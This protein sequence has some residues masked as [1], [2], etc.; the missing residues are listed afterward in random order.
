M[1]NETRWWDPESID[2]GHSL[3]VASI[4]EK[5][6]GYAFSYA[7]VEEV[8]AG[9]VSLELSPWPE[10]DE[11]GSPEFSD[12]RGSGL[13]CSEDGEPVRIL[14]VISQSLEEI[15]IE[16]FG[17]S[18]NARPVRVGDV[19]GVAIDPRELPSAPGR[20]LE[21]KKLE[22]AIRSPLYDVTA[23]ARTLARIALLTSLSPA[24]DEK[25]PVAAL[26]EEAPYEWEG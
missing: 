5:W 6:S 18:L 17:Q 19:F 4:M 15:P 2:D 26:L 23:E 8:E 25:D 1:A 9:I 24:L 3:N 12:A 20:P 10:L 7:V 22:S 14:E 11:E 21:G 13:G 16:R